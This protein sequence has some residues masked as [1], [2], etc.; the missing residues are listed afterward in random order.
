VVLDAELRLARLLRSLVAQEHLHT[1][2]DLSEGGF[3]I[4]L[5]EACFGRRTMGARVEIPL[6]GADLFS[7]TQ[8]RALVA[9]PPAALEQVLEA[10]EAM[11]VPAREIGETG[12]A[13]LVLKSG[14]E[15]LSAPV[16]RLHEVWS[17][18]LPRALGL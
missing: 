16:A 18:A 14:G 9:V 6:A 10:A 4:A 7:E 5:A 1:A 2:H 13:D 8:G 15:V 11:G 12:G 17:T 3:L